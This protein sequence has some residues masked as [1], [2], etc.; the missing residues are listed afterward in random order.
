[1][2][3][4]K[5]RNANLWSI[6]YRSSTTVGEPALLI[7]ATTGEIAGR[8]ARRFLKKA[9]HRKIEIFRFLYR[10]TIDVF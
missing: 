5:K 8:K 4:K 3:T 7:L 2:T 9:G 1:M 10:G 6:A